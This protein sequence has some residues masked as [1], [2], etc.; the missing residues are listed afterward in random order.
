MARRKKDPAG[1]NRREMN[2]KLNRWE[3]KAWLFGA[4]AGTTAG[5]AVGLLLWA[6]FF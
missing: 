4:L 5:T 6:C 1:A 2:W 3:T